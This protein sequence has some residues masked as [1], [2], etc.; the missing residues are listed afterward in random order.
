MTTNKTNFKKWNEL[1]EEEK[2]AKKDARKEQLNAL[3]S[4]MQKGIQTILNSDEYKHY[5]NVMNS[6]HQYSINNTLL[7]YAQCQKQGFTPTYIKGFQAWKKLNRFVKKGAKAIKIYAPVHIHYVK[8][9]DANKCAL[10][11]YGEIV[12]DETVDFTTFKIENVFDISQTDG[13]AL[14]RLTRDLLNDV[15]NFDNLIKALITISPCKVMFKTE[16]ED[17]HLKNAY[18]YYHIE[19]N[20]IVVKQ[21]IGKLH[22]IKTLCH[23]IAHACMHNRMVQGLENVSPF[24]REIQA[25]SVAYMLCSYLQLDTSEYSFNYIAREIDSTDKNA[26][27]AFTKNLEIIKACASALIERLEKVFEENKTETKTIKNNVAL[28]EENTEKKEEK[29]SKKVDA[30]S[31]AKTRKKA[32]KSATLEQLNLF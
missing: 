20:Y 25:E 28:L 31:K 23:E 4:E 13:E 7:I 32:S 10:V 15:Q 26:I 5:L 29:A 11:P 14:P 3:E 2:Q 18:G 21:N 27:K 19:N 30:K 1:T 8:E 24:D 16:S 9:Q 17:E 12:E 22:A 6:F